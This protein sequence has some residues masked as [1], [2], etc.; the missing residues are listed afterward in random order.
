M[1]DL[2]LKEQDSLLLLKNKQGKTLDSDVLEAVL[3]AAGD[4]ISA[5]ELASI[6]QTDIFTVQ[7]L[8][9]CLSETLAKRKSGL[10]LRSVAGGF[11]LVTRP[12]LFYAVERL[13]QVIE[14][15]LSAPTMETLSIIAFK[16]PITKTEIEQIR[17][18][19]TERA[20]AKLLELELI[21]EMGR[22]KVV[23]RPILYGTT[24]NFLQSFGLASLDDL[25]SLPTSEEAIKDLDPEQLAL[26]QGDIGEKDAELMG[27]ADASEE[28]A[29]ASADETKGGKPEE[30]ERNSLGKNE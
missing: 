13:G 28:T 11:Q 27:L 12:D 21:Q 9:T 6:L 30:A 18:V 26:I 16:Q 24:D 14:R 22:K 19:R 5:E 3:F 29:G 23:G 4:P 2:P 15:R 20:L 10:A 7:T 25:P 1:G 8:L 17:G